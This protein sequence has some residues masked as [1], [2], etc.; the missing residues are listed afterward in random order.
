MSWTRYSLDDNAVEI[1]NNCFT[2]FGFNYIKTKIQ[3][4]KWKIVQNTNFV[5]NLLQMSKIISWVQFYF[6]L[7][8]VENEW[9]WKNVHL[10]DCDACENENRQ[11]WVRRKQIIIL[12]IED[13]R[14]RQIRFQNRAHHEWQKM[15][16]CWIVLGWLIWFVLNV[17]KTKFP[18]E[19]L[20]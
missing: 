4:W 18:D 3:N 20:I 5:K 7:W 9:E 8:F 16:A 19:L 10:C 12:M 15:N 14:S 13:S 17:S 11:H 6:I 2:P 1:D